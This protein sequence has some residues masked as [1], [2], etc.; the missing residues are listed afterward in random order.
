MDLAAIASQ[1]AE[2]GSLLNTFVK[3]RVLQLDADFGCYE[4][5]WLDK[6]LQENIIQLKKLIET[7]RLTA[8]AEF[9]NVHITLGMKG[10][11]NQM[12]TVKPYQEKRNKLIDPE[13]TARV[14]ALRNFLANYNT[15]ITTPIANVLQEADDSLTIMQLERI[16][17]FGL[18]SSVIMSG[19]KDLWMSEGL[20]CE[21]KTGDIYEVK[22]YGKTEWKEVGN[23]KPKL[24]GRG[25]SWF[26]HQLLHGDGADNIAG[27]P[28]LS[29]KLLN[30]YLPTKKI[31]PKRA[32]QPCGEA[33]SYA[34]LKGVTNNR[35]AC[36]RVREAYIECYREG[37]ALEMLI[38]QAFLL[39]MRRTK[40]LDDVL[41]FLTESGM[42]AVFSSSQTQRLEEYKRLAKI[43][44]QESDLSNS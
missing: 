5:S 20:H 13:K 39:W 2:S 33:K 35:E 29:G 11:R 15:D 26:W 17:E 42:I 14:S 30:R 6:S 19:D 37:N 24:V 27:L 31:N 28:K 9:V 16:A 38:E 18:K 3:G 1:A 40:K 41:D 21:Q 32:S 12:A 10:G 43:Q 8:G 7:C 23:V 34:I 44:L 4:C 25:T 22:G 36:K